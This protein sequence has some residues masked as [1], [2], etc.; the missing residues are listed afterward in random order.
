MALAVFDIKDIERR[1]QG[2]VAT[3]KHEF[4]GLRTGRANI[5]LLDPIMVDA[6]GSRTPIMQVATVT[7]PEP[8][9][10]AVNVWDRA[11]VSAVERAIRDSN[12]S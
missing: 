6:Y 3:L 11:L 8:R 7:V 12:P 5:N 9:L 2:G 1:M 10:L 4:G